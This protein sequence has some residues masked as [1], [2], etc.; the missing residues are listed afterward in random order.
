MPALYLIGIMS[1]FELGVSAAL[2]AFI[3][4][5]QPIATG[6]FAGILIGERTTARHGCGLLLGALSVALIVSDSYTQTDVCWFALT[7]PFFAMLALC[8]GLLLNRR[9]EL[10][11]NA[12][13]KKPEPVMLLL[14]VHALGALIMIL[15]LAAINGELHWQFTH[16]QWNAI[17]WPALVVSLGS[18]ALLLFLLR[19]I[20]A[21]RVTS[22]TYLVSPS[23]MLQS[24]LFF[25][26]TF[27]LMNTVVLCV[28]G[29][30]VYMILT[31]PP[32]NTA[33]VLATLGSARAARNR[34]EQIFTKICHYEKL[35]AR[36]IGRNTGTPSS[37]SN[38]KASPAPP[39]TVNIRRSGW[40]L[41]TAR[42]GRNTV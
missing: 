28:T 16:T 24:Y 5:L 22:L 32:A 25:G 27:S 36:I 42:S 15:P 13:G 33:P 4:T 10:Q 23:T 2:V 20:S 14:L 26:E 9:L 38:R 29:V 3:N 34:L 12:F 1:A 37:K 31:D 19:H 40:Q 11:S 21:I 8:A 18:Y 17:V 6:V 39:F 7:L 41:P 30:A 35:L